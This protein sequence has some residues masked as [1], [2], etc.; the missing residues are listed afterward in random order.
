M[1]HTIVT[2]SLHTHQEIEV[3]G[4]F[5][6]LE[7]RVCAGRSVGLV[8]YPTTLAPVSGTVTVDAHCAD[9]AHLRSGSSLSIMCVYCGSWFGLIPACECNA[10]YRP[11]SM[12]DK[13]V[14]VSS[15]LI[16]LA[17]LIFP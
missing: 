3:S 7:P 16:N 17:P 5:I 14:K 10:G 9:N 2:V 8:C 15:S 4:Q 6:S 13:Y 12:V 11:V 1:V